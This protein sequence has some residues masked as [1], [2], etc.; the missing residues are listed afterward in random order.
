[1]LVLLRLYTKQNGICACGC[2]KVMNLNRDKI[3]CDH[4]IPLIDGGEN[5]ETNLQLMFA[6]CHKAKTSAES[7]QRS[8]ARQHQAK[9]FAR[10][11]SKMRGPGFPKAKPQLSASSPLSDKFANLRKAFGHD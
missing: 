9:A 7:S 1:M 4:K 3:D 5:R 11:P 10:P 2:T 8:E 6:A